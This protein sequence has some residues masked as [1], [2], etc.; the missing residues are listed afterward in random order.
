M[1]VVATLVA[2]VIVVAALATVLA[3]QI[4]ALRRTQVSLVTANTD[5]AG[6]GGS[7]QSEGHGFGLEASDIAWFNSQWVANRAMLAR[8]SSAVLVHTKGLGSA[9]WR[10][11]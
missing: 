10:S 2:Q 8:I 4:V 9:L 7:M 3:R 11:R 6:S 5:L 1:P